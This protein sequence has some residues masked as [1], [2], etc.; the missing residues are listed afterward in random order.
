MKTKDII[1]ITAMLLIA[2]APLLHGQE[3][4][5]DSNVFGHVIDASTDEHVP[6]INVVIEGTRIGTITDGSGHY[7]LTN[8]PVGK[9]TLVVLGM[10][11]ETQRIEIEIDLGQTL[12]VDFEV[13]YVGINL[14]DIVVTASPTASGFRYQPD[15]AYLGEQL[16]RR[17][18]VSFGE[19]LNFS[20]GI[21]MRSFGSAPAR[22]VIRG[23]DGDRILVLENGERMGD[24]SETSADHAIAM[25]PMVA[26]RIEV[27]RGPASLLYGPSAL[28]GVINLMT[29]DIPD[30]WDFGSSG[31]LSSQYSS[32][33]RMGAGFA[34]YTHGWDSYAISGRFAYREGGDIRTPAGRVPGTSMRNTDGA[35]GFGFSGDRAT[36]GI[37]FSASDQEYEVPESSL[38]DDEGVYITMQRVALQGRVAM[39]NS[40][41]FFDRTQ[42]RFNASRMF[43]QEIE[44]EY[45]DGLRDEDVELEYLKHTFSSTAT[46]QHKPFSFFDR[47]AVGLNL[48]G[49]NLDVSGDEAYTPGE[50]RFNMGLFTFQEIPITN[51][52]RFQAGV[53]FDLMHIGAMENELFPGIRD[54][55][56]AINYSGSFGFNHRPIEGLEIGGQFARSHRNPSVEELFANGVHIGA[57]VYELGNSNLRD[58][59]GQGTD[60]FINWNR[61]P[62]VM[63]AAFFVNHFRNYIIFESTGTTDDDS[64]YPV[65]RYRGE[66]ARLAGAELSAFW[67]PHRRVEI[68]MAADFVTG[69]VIADE[70]SYLP[71]IPP[72]RIRGEVEYDY[73]RGWVGARVTH[74]ARQDRVATEEDP[75]D[76][77]T[78]LALSAGYRIRT[79]VMQLIILRVDNLLDQEYRDHLSRIED[80]NYPMPGRNIS[81][82]YRLMF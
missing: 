6:F 9:H 48:Y 42:F 57:G 21:S 41:S 47:G 61:N 66:E 53:R 45:D 59:I 31:L 24:V 19:I 74:A 3:G 16:Q 2:A 27:V 20:P 75:T 1:A 37:S 50:R 65:F 33:N 10:G 55:R 72:F 25:D 73:D 76:G 7:I 23:L 43:Q 14:D 4:E 28:G 69:K 15:I 56:F 78:L 54:N 51:T 5:T 81:L 34:R 39:Q 32:M 71:F 17:N 11:Y 29:T 35:L 62:L 46:L 63:E 60:F 49:H 40:S 67:T 77:Y 82:T 8:L 58:E 68:G 80:R 22:P 52:M 13:N 26:S 64:G 12:E 44:Y 79:S 18:E 38:I 36:G 70:E 30:R